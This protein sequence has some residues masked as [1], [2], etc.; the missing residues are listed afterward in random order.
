MIDKRERF[1]FW[2]LESQTNKTNIQEIFGK[3]GT[4]EHDFQEAFQHYRVTVF[5]ASLDLP[6]NE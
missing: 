6:I 2:I 5:F 1:V 4:E 3:E